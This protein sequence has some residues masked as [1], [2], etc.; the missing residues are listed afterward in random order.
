VISKTLTYTFLHKHT[1]ELPLGVAA[2]ALTGWFT[3]ALTGGAAVVV[4]ETIKKETDV[5]IVVSKRIQ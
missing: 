5:M 2:V 4:L 3:V 1:D